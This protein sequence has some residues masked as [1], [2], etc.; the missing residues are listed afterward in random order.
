MD[1]GLFHAKVNASKMF[2]PIGLH[3]TFTTETIVMRRR[4]L[5]EVSEL[6]KR[7]PIRLK[8]I[9]LLRKEPTQRSI[10]YIADY[11]EEDM[12]TIRKT[13]A[14]MRDAKEA[15]RYGEVWGLLSKDAF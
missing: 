11:L 10:K 13:L 15:E 5:A 12:G 7:V 6:S 14:R 3:I 9:G 8:I 2:A 1:I 4:S